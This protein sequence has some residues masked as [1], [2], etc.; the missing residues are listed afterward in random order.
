MA[1]VNDSGTATALNG[2]EADIEASFSGRYYYTV[3][4]YPQYGPE[5]GYATDEIQPNL[6]GCGDCDW[7][8]A[9][10]RPSRRLRVKPK[11]TS[12]TPSR[13]AIASQTSVTIQGRGFG[14]NPSVLPGGTGLSYSGSGGSATQLTGTLTAAANATP[15][16]HSIQ[17]GTN[18]QT[19]NSVQFF[20]QVP[21]KILPYTASSLAPDGIGPIRTPVNADVRTLEGVLVFQNFCGVYRSYLFFLADQEGQRIQAAFTFDEIFSNVNSPPTLAAPAY[22]P[23]NFPANYVAIEDLQSVGFIGGCLNT[24]EFQT[25]TQRFKITIGG[26][27]FFP[28]TTINIKRGNEGGV[29][30]VDRTITTP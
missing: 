16:N 26:T 14:S 28:T 22:T 5:R 3:E 13:G 29:L 24:N 21:S 25:F 7:D 8:L 20:V 30:K 10:R 23:V 1:S 19:S 27:E 18:G 2:G 6:P 17:V 4:C 9:Q 11:I 15:G 12:I